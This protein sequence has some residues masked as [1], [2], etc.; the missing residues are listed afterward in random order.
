MS[1]IKTVTCECT[2]YSTA[3]EVLRL[4]RK[5]ELIKT[6][7][8]TLLTVTTFQSAVLP[9]SSHVHMLAGQFRLMWA[10]PFALIKSLKKCL[11]YSC[12][13][14]SLYPSVWLPSKHS[15]VADLFLLFLRTQL[16]NIRVYRWLSEQRQR[17]GIGGRGGRMSGWEGNTA[18]GRQQLWGAK[19]Q[20]NKG[21][22]VKARSDVSKKKKEGEPVGEGEKWQRKGRQ[23]TG[24]N[25][26]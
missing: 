18:M 25:K 20:Q 6:C 26:T 10:L 12:S 16:C 14:W 17:S 3:Q 7:V 9:H 13:W 8:Q 11:T 23:D 15:F 24:K 5:N 4:T 22:V 21:H 19:L 2:C 1:F